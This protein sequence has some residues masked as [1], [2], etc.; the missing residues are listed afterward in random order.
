MDDDVSPN[1][2]DGMGKDEVPL[3]VWMKEREEA[4]AANPAPTLLPVSFGHEPD[5]DAADY[6]RLPGFGVGHYSLTDASLLSALDMWVSGT[7]P[8]VTAEVLGDRD[9]DPLRCLDD[10]EVRKALE[11]LQA[12]LLA[13]LIRSAEAG[14][15]DVEVRARSLADSR[16][17]PSRTYV[18]LHE[19][20]E[21]LDVHGHGRGD[22]IAVIEEE[23]DERPWEIASGVAEQR[24]NFRL[25]HLLQQ[26]EPATA[27]PNAGASDR[28]EREAEL[29]ACRLRVAH[30]ERQIDE[31]RRGGGSGRPVTTR[32]R[33]T[34]LTVIAA[35]CRKAGI[36]P[37]SRGAAVAI[38]SATA[39]LGTPV[40]DDSIRTMLRE[41][42]DA[43]ESRSR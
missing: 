5:Y 43:V 36:D 11:P 42:P 10:P 29:Q 22:V 20:V 31:L 17:D 18:D 38:E 9:D 12:Q 15:L 30:L 39:E 35:L 2:P 34:Y 13:A 33:R 4:M 37:N 26:D 27:N 8:G 40:G 1:S 7:A 19:L 24:A 32:A 28:Y 3:W 25:A 14:Q 21:W 6:L 16:L 41:I 23:L